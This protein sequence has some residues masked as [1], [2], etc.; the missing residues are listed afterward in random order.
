MMLDGKFFRAVDKN[1]WCIEERLRDMDKT[2]EM[3]LYIETGVS[4]IR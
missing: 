1:C 2:G 4:S 3:R